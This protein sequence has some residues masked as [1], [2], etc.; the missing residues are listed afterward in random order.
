MRGSLRAEEL[1]LPSGRVAAQ[2]CGHREGTGDVLW[3]LEQAGSHSLSWQMHKVEIQSLQSFTSLWFMGAYGR[4]MQMCILL[5]DWN[6][7]IN[8]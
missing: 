5:D 3:N 8:A 6:P 4:V 2:S 1:R 7:Q